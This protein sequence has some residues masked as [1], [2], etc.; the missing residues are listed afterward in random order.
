[1]GGRRYRE[2]CDIECVVYRASRVEHDDGM[3]EGTNTSSAMVLNLRAANV[4][5]SSTAGSRWHVW[6]ALAS[7]C[8]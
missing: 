1:M 3:V 4:H 6:Q 8:T 2:E 7:A 5:M